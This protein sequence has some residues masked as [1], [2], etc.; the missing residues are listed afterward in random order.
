[1]ASYVCFT[2]INDTYPRDLGVN[3]YSFFLL[4]NFDFQWLP[5]GFFSPISDALSPFLWD[6]T[7]NCEI[8]KKKWCLLSWGFLCTTSFELKLTMWI[9]YSKVGEVIVV[10]KFWK[11][12]TLKINMTFRH[13]LLS[14][15][16]GLH[17][18]QKFIK[19]LAKPSCQT[20][21]ASLFKI[22]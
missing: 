1:M 16:S 19:Y 10:N 4:N 18:C 14:N 12:L 3:E 13:G 15:L 11:L 6:N 21:R 17:L 2:L 8:K 22:P 7:S 5:K 9:I 20:A